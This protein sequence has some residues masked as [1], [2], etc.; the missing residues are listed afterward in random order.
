M[1]SR[2]FI[3]FYEV[4]ELDPNSSAAAIDHRFRQLARLYHPDNAET[5]D[6][7]RFDAVVEAHGTLKEP[8]RRAKYHEDNPHNLPPF[9]PAPNEAE[10][11]DSEA[12]E[13]YVD[14]LGIDKDL[15][16]Q[17]HALTLLYQRRR[18]NIREPGIGNGE[19]ENL[20]GC[21]HEHLEFHLWYLREKG[22]IARGD[23][24][25]Y[26]ITIEGVDRA[27][28]LFQENAKRRITDQS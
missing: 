21:P 15:S 3:N 6:R 9:E 28:A 23:D 12:D 20:T 2:L 19:L 25:L 26:A 16:I 22:W 4:L 1:E 7:A 18:K 10:P 14:P 5:G 13:A 8:G 17:N 27:A 11:G 24:G